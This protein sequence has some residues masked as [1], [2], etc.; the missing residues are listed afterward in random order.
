M[1]GRVPG[2]V[3]K[4]NENVSHGKE[5]CEP[6]DKNEC[7]NKC[8]ADFYQGLENDTSAYS[9]FRSSASQCQ[10]MNSSIVATCSQYCS[11]KK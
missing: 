10:Q 7:M 1:F 2:K 5:Q 3:L 11:A 4:Y 6:D 8:V 9:W